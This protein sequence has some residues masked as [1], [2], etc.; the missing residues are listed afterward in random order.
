MRRL[1]AAADRAVAALIALGRWLVLPVSLLLFLQWPLREAIH[2]YSVEANDLAQWLFALYV[3]LAVTFAT[4]EGTHLAADSFARRYGP[5]RRAI[6]AKV[7]ALIAIL[8]WSLLV[9]VAGA[10]GA[11]QSLA[12][13][14]Q[15]P[16]TYDPGYFIVKLSTML[17]AAL[18]LVQALID[19]LRPLPAPRRA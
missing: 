2:A 9:L 19:L 3:S 10:P 6:I 16:E 14:E 13:L 4:R 7:A 15:F 17:L 12:G 8:P 11:W 18:L 5:Q 1:L